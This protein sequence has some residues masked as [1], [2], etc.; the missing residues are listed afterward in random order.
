MDM[1]APF[2]IFSSF[3]LLFSTLNISDHHT[4]L[5]K[6]N[7]SKQKIEIMNE[8]LK[9]SEI[10]AY[11]ALYGKHKLTVIYHVWKAELNFPSHTRIQLLTHPFSIKASVMWQPFITFIN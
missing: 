7:T 3:V 10:Q 4:N 5:D 11:S 2:L 9:E 8:G 1:F 6:D